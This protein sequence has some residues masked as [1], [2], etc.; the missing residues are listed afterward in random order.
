[1]FH[2][3]SVH[4]RCGLDGSRINGAVL[5]KIGPVPGEVPP[6][7]AA[8]PSSWYEASPRFHSPVAKASS[9]LVFHEQ[10]TSA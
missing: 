10:V 8:C 7:V 3:S 4:W 1:M 6:R 5:Q 2:R 9:D